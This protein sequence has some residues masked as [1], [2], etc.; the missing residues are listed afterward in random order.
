MKEFRII[1]F[2]FFL[3]FKAA[4][5]CCT[6]HFSPCFLPPLPAEKGV[7]LGQSL[8]ERRARFSMVGLGFVRLA[9]TLVLLQMEPRSCCSNQGGG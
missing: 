2:S 6:V 8:D 7:I 3:Y 1:F 5:Y 4:V 9:Y